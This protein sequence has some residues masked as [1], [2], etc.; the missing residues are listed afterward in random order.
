MFIDEV[1]MLDC[2]VM[3]NLHSQLT[4]AESKPDIPFGGVN[5][6]FLGD[7]L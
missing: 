4:K 1:S 2:K 7:F 3:E 6:I 5:I